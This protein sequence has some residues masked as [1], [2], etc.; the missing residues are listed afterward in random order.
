MPEKR[1]LRKVTKQDVEELEKVTAGLRKR[2]IK[3]PE[4][5]DN[6]MVLK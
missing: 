5:E 6:Y 4:P 3:Y 2:E 1:P